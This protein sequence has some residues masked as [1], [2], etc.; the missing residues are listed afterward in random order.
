MSIVDKYF[1]IDTSN[2]IKCFDIRLSN[3]SMNDIDIRNDIKSSN[4]SMDD[5]KSNDDIRISDDSMDDVKSNDV[6]YTGK[7]RL[8]EDGKINGM[9]YLDMY[10][11]NFDSYKITTTVMIVEFNKE[12]N[13]KA[14]F[15]LLPITHVPFMK[16]RGS[17]KCKLPHCDVIGAIISLKQDDQVRGIVKSYK[18]GFKHSISIDISVSIKNINVQLSS[19]KMKISGSPSENGELGLEGANLVINH[20]QNIQNVI[21]K[22]KAD[23]E[24]AKKTIDWIIENTK[25]DKITRENRTSVG[26]LIINNQFEDHIIISPKYFIPDE[27]DID[28]ARFLLSLVSD[29][30]F[31]SEMS[32]KIKSILNVPNVIK[33]IGNELLK[34]DAMNFAMV[35]YNYHL[36][37]KI[38]LKILD[39]KIHGKNNFFSHYNND[40]SNCVT[41]ELAYDSS[42]NPAIKK[43][44]NQVPRITFLCYA[45]GSVTHSGP[46]GDIMRES[47]YLFMITMAEI[48]KYIME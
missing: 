5:A 36:S 39:E 26:K 41:I 21:D 29:F 38:N 30:I 23:D 35:N 12:I 6:K 2:D 32:E 44:K 46:G 22:I 27:L 13:E 25:G 8:I 28:I 14:L 7:L 17:S 33:E 20:I 4:E 43:K 37:F 1:D 19:K 16:K 45:T 31:H 48:K 40:L 34:I 47:Y 24:I 10:I 42:I 11:P 15:H 3:D 9:R 18:K